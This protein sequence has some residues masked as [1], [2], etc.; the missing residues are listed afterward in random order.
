MFGEAVPGV[1][2]ADADAGAVAV[3]DGAALGAYV[4]IETLED[5]V[6]EI[7]FASELCKTT[8]RDELRDANVDI[9][10]GK[11]YVDD[12]IT[13]VANEGFV[14]EAEGR[15]V[16]SVEGTAPP[17]DAVP[18]IAEGMEGRNDTQPP[19]E[20]TVREK[21]RMQA[22]ARKKMALDRRRA[23]QAKAAKKRDAEGA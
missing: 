9:L 10:D 4:S 19:T 6:C 1:A 12:W 16:C 8:V 21:V 11:I 17:K 18:T 14:C 2:L 22:E 20:L 5:E 15:L 3:V 23:K 7:D 13:L